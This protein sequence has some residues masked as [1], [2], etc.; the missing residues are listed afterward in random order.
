MSL[1]DRSD[2]NAE[3]YAAEHRHRSSRPVDHAE[4][5]FR[6]GMVHLGKTFKKPVVC[7]QTKIFYTGF[8]LGLYPSNWR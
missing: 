3:H 8:D 5:I 6:Q 7:K 1:Y 4:R 2:I